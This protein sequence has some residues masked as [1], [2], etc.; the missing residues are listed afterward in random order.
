MP[1]RTM[2]ESQIIRFI[3]SME[4]QGVGVTRTKKGLFLRLPDTT[5][6]TVHFTNSD[7]RAI[8]NLMARL[9][10]AGVRHPDDPKDVRELPTNITEAKPVAARSIRRIKQVVADLGWPEVI[11]VKEV[12]ENS[13]MVHITATRALYQM[14]FIPVKG[15]RNAR[16][17]LTPDELL[18][19]K[20]VEQEPESPTFDGPLLPEQDAAV[21]R[22][23][24]AEALLDEAINPTRDEAEVERLKSLGQ[25][26]VEV[27][28]EGNREF[29]DTHESWVLDLTQLGG[30]PFTATPIT[31]EQLRTVMASAGLEME[32]RVW[33]K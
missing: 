18:A 21:G 25:P 32:V 10:R 3:H 22:A 13:D 24:E 11:T 33:R 1:S 31:V 5:S 12:V 17:W 14:G 28:V 16:A 23:E 7:V 19:E 30:F 27:K 26:T 29:I 8:D 15:K 9:R 2:S 6:T 20:P 4:D